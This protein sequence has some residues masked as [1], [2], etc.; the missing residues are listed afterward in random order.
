MVADYGIVIYRLFSFLPSFLQDGCFLLF[1]LGLQDGLILAQECDK[2]GEKSGYRKLK[3]WTMIFLLVYAVG[4]V[5]TFFINVSLR[6]EVG[7]NLYFA[8]QILVLVLIILVVFWSSR[9]TRKSLQKHGVLYQKARTIH[10]IL[11]GSLLLHFTLKLMTSIL[12]LTNVLINLKCA[13]YNDGNNWHY[14]GYL[15]MHYMFNEYVPCV[16]MIVIL[17]F[18]ERQNVRLR[19][20]NSRIIVQK[21]L[22]SKVLK[23]ESRRGSRDMSRQTRP[24]IN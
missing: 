8:Y 24:S 16:V 23:D 1:A 10:I 22:G 18:Q 13:G 21:L 12:F 6:D 14:V 5:T 9:E 11:L 7:K 20:S 17:T 3:M 19:N 2:G 15:A 4:Y